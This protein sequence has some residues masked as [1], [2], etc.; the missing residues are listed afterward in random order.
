M[1][2]CLEKWPVPEMGR[3]GTHVNGSYEEGMWREGCRGGQGFSSGA[4]LSIWFST[5]FPS[6]SLPDALMGHRS[7]LHF[8]SLR[9]QHLHHS[10]LFTC[11]YLPLFGPPASVRVG[12]WLCTPMV[13]SLGK[14]WWLTAN[15]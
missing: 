7:Y 5:S 13:V 2:F 9:V 10:C 4:V 8:S 3:Q 11:L 1:D 14:A 6:K 15:R 12:T